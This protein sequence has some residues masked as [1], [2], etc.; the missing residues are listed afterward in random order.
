[1]ID[2]EIMSKEEVEEIVKS[3]FDYYSSELQSVEQ[4]EPEKSY[5]KKQWEGFSQAPSDITTWDT[6]VGWELLS[7]I[8]RNSVYHPP[9]FVKKL[10]L[11]C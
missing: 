8:G 6:G 4:Y 11:F 7:Y 2:E 5:F 3:Q 1:M 10:K 9:D